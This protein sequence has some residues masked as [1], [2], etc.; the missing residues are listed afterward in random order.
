MVL[1]EAIVRLRSFSS[2]CISIFVLMSG[3]AM[4][5]PVHPCPPGMPV[6]GA[7]IGMLAS[8][9]PVVAL[10]A[11]SQR[12]SHAA[13][14]DNQPDASTVDPR[15]SQRVTLALKGASLEEFCAALQDQI[16]VECR[17]ARDVSEDKV[18]VFVKDQPAREVMD[19]IKHLFGYFWLRT[20]KE[21]SYRYELS[22]D[23][24]SRLAEEDLRRRDMNAALQALD[25]AMQ[26]YRP[27]VDLKFDELKT[28]YAKAA[29][30]E[31]ERLQMLVQGGGWGGMQ[32]Y[33]RLR[34]TERT[35]LWR[36]QS[37]VF[38]PDA[39]D[40]TRRLPPEWIGS[41]VASM[42]STS[43]PP[44][45]PDAATERTDK[46]LW[47][48]ILHLDR[49]DLGQVVL[50]VSI[51]VNG[52]EGVSKTWMRLADG[53]PTL[54]N[55]DNPKENENLRREKGFQ[56]L[57]SVHPESSCPKL[58]QKKPDPG[59]L[60]TPHVF[61][62][63]VWEA[64]HRSTG[65]SIVA[66]YF[67]RLYAPADVTFERVSL[68][69]ALCRGGDAM[70]VRWSK[71]GNFLLGR[72]ARFCWDRLKEVPKRSLQR[73]QQ[74]KQAD[75]GLPLQSLIEMA[76]LSDDQLNA[77]ALGEST[78]VGGAIMHCWGL[79]EW[80]LVA[81]VP[82]GFYHRGGEF[83]PSSLPPHG[84]VRYYRA[85]ENILWKEFWN[86]IS[87]REELRFFGTL[88]PDQQQRALRPD[89]I[90]LS[91][92]RAA[93]QRS[94][95]Q[96]WNQVQQLQMQDRGNRSSSAPQELQTGRL[97]AEYVPAGWYFWAAP[98]TSQKPWV[99]DPPRT[100]FP[101]ATEAL[102]AARRINP[103][104]R[105]EQIHQCANGDFTPIIWLGNRPPQVP[106]E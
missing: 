78:G 22:Q 54:D 80:H 31:R 61:S 53:H 58:R 95:R 11:A 56:E 48:V 8:R 50:S 102:V 9:P 88:T 45:E 47:R 49:S 81:S 79:N 41:I 100:A 82:V 65:R 7:G 84:E 20:T 63:D 62:A 43:S 90:V 24:K 40:S 39:S 66:D 94:F 68:Y 106:S 23:L 51:Y 74:A 92:L 89:G 26:V 46:D 83:G 86:P 70:G 104:A 19:A 42:G 76:S 27:Y 1:R 44:G 98:W 36:D 16:N 97:A 4:A 71:A 101:T 28:R 37:L 103:S 5:H 35:V 60:K 25:R 32:L 91:E 72:S 30:S 17:A 105:P 13:N 57:I 93:Q 33:F 87:L 85:P 67:S 15:L 96:L 99:N 38:S 3:F 59:E 2:L 12:Q 77:G 21:G 18:T 73:W 10:T 75:G 52:K 64:I 69:E 34:P 29:E 55:L 14:E 6:A